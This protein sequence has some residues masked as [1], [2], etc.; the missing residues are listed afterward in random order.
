[1]EKDIK[2][3]LISEQ[4]INQRCKE[5]GAQISQDYASKT[6]ILVGLL[7]GSVP[8]M[9]ELLKNVSVHCETEYM[10]VSSYHGTSSTG[11]VRIIKD[12]DVSIE[13]RDIIIVED[14]VDT[15]LTLS[16]IINMFLQRHARSVEIACLLDKKEGRR[17]GVVLHPKYVGFD[18]PNEF[19]VGFGLDYDEL[20]RNLPYVGVLKEEV[21]S[22]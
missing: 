20:Y 14:I 15:G 19:V 1:M 12:L 4:E 5:L 17:P 21:Y 18:V 16:T 3:V 8:F 13:N 9:A 7:K 11:E 10:A 6:P 2:K 22:K